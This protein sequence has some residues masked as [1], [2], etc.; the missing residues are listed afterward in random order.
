MTIAAALVTAP[1][2][3]YNTFVHVMQIN[4]FCFITINAIAYHDKCSWLG[5][6][7]PWLNWLT[8]TC[9]NTV[10]PNHCHVYNDI[11]MQFYQQV[12]CFCMNVYPVYLD[13]TRQYL[14]FAAVQTCTSLLHVHSPAPKATPCCSCKMCCWC[15]SCDSWTN[16][17]KEAS[18][19]SV[20]HTLLLQY[21]KCIYEWCACKVLLAFHVQASI[22]TPQTYE[23]LLNKCSN[24]WRQFKS[25]LLCLQTFLVFF[26]TKFKPKASKPYCCISRAHAQSCFSTVQGSHASVFCR[27]SWCFSCKHPIQ[28][29]RNAPGC[30]T[31]SGACSDCPQAVQNALRA[32][33]HLWR[34][35]LE[36][37][38]T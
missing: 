3:L 31:L 4:V 36:H 15:C 5:H 29:L 19:W 8:W 13:S 16:C 22:V 21:S 24:C 27:Y 6:T 1:L 33:P 7:I 30:W 18:V 34:A 32:L 2:G 14:L 26:D 35:L 12:F 25:V 20:L 38:K 28:C 17:P 10:S 37:P 23:Q 11:I 9:W